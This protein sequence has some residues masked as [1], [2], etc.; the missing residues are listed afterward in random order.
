MRIVW[1]IRW[2]GVVVGVAATCVAFWMLFFAMG[3]PLL[4]TYLS[5]GVELPTGLAWYAHVVSVTVPPLASWLLAFALGGLVVGVVVPAFS[6]LNGALG[7]ATTL[8]GGFAWFVGPALVSAVPWLWEPVSNPGEIYTRA[9]TLSKLIEISVV[10]CAV[11]PLIVLAGYVGGRVG[12]LLRGR[13]N[14]HR[15]QS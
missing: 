9:D 8:F 14:Q 13:F 6:G 3:L 5:E 12:T 7:A 11:F 15:A 1:R 2:L 10:F 4:P